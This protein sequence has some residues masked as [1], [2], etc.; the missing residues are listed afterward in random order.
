MKRLVLTV[1]LTTLSAGAVAC[2]SDKLRATYQMTELSHDGQHKNTREL[3]LWRNGHQV[4]HQ[5]PHSEI[6]EIWNQN[7]RGDLHLER[8]FDA[9][10]HGIE[11]QP[12]EIK[13]NSWEI[14]YQLVSTEFMKELSLDRTVGEG[15]DRVEYWVS[16]TKTPGKGKVALEWMPGQ[17]LVK[18]LSVNTDN[19]S[20]EWTLKDIKTDSG[21][22]DEIFSIHR[23]YK[24]T[25]YAD[26]G[27]NESDPFLRKMIN[28]GFVSHGPSGFYNTEGHVLESAQKHHH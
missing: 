20:T 12:G 2:D 15:C 28:L 5:Y 27:D 16:N 22:V 7:S 13:G 24:L 14:K 26:V 17:K 4:A 25:D 8:Y 19:G 3:V 9:Y 10:Q 11:Y 1:A 18:K 21:L 6:T 23:A